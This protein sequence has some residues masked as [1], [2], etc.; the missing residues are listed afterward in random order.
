MFHKPILTLCVM[1]F[2][3]FNS[4]LFHFFFFFIFVILVSTNQNELLTHSWV[5]TLSLKNPV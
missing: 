2:E 3:I 5:T 1:C 4:I